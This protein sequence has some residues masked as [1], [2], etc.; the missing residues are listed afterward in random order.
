MLSENAMSNVR[1][2]L[3]ANWNKRIKDEHVGYWRDQ[4]GKH[5][6]SEDNYKAH[7][8]AFERQYSGNYA[9]KLA[10]IKRF[11][12]SRALPGYGNGRQQASGCVFCAGTRWLPIAVPHK[13]DENGV[14]WHAAAVELEPGGVWH[15]RLYR[16]AIPC[17][18]SSVPLS[19][20]ED[21]TRQ[22]FC[23][24]YRRVAE[25]EDT[26]CC[27]P[28]L[29]DWLRRHHRQAVEAPGAEAE[30]REYDDV[31]DDEIPF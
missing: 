14:D 5:G 23:G 26:I 4:L 22:K 10:E 20:D 25:S 30:N 13:E 15:G 21:A 18:C 28:H 9:P 3:E 2:W 6:L 27:E 31:A 1:Q 17:V 19:P 12:R 29:G 8:D 7:L 16:I 24:W 11:L